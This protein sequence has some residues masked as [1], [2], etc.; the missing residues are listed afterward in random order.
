[1]T[2]ASK[3]GKSAIIDIVDYC[4]RAVPFGLQVAQVQKASNRVRPRDRGAGKSAKPGRE[5]VKWRAVFSGD[6]G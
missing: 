6:F 2:G 3:T 4:R 5:F 1:V